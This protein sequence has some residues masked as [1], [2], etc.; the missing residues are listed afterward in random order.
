MR[1]AVLLLAVASL[2]VADRPPRNGGVPDKDLLQGTWKLVRIEV[3]NQGNLGT[4]LRIRGNKFTVKE[5]TGTL[6]EGSIRLSASHGTKQLDLIVTEAPSR[7]VVRA[8]YRLERNTWTM[9]LNL[10]DRPRPPDFA[11][12]NSRRIYIWVRQKR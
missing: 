7:Y 3:G 8:I 5:K 12:T 10:P 2:G 1:W 6:T 11:A 4:V 9:C